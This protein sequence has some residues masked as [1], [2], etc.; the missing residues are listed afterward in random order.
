MSL[1]VASRLSITLQD[2]VVYDKDLGRVQKVTLL[3]QILKMHK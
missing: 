3:K 1:L 2:L